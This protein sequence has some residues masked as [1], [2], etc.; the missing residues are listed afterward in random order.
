MAHSFFLFKYWSNVFDTKVTLINNL[1]TPMLQSQNPTL[2]L[3]SSSLDY[4]ALK[5]FGC[6]VFPLLRPY[7]QYKFSYGSTCYV[8]LGP[9]MNHHGHHCLEITTR[10]FYISRHVH[11]IESQFL[12]KN[13]TVS[14]PKSNSIEN[15]IPWLQVHFDSMSTPRM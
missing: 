13:T 7:N 1:P 5:V 4:A 9:S 14:L 15:P 6:S 3:F 12:F 8:Y 11:F 2:K 10:R